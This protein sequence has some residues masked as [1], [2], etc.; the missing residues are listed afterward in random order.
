MCGMKNFLYWLQE[1]RMTVIPVILVIVISIFNIKLLAY[2]ER[3]WGVFSANDFAFAE[4]PYE[5]KE[6]F[7]ELDSATNSLASTYSID[8]FNTEEQINFI[9]IDSGYLL[10]KNNPL[11]DILPSRDGL[12]IYKVQKGDNLAKIA[13]NFGISLNTIL[14]A[15][16]DLNSNLLKIGQEV[17]I[18][19]VSGVLH[20]ILLGDTIES[21]SEKYSVSVNK[22]V[23]YNIGLSPSKLESRQTIIV[24]YAKP[25]QSSSMAQKLP[26][27][28]GYFAIPTTGWNWGILHNYNAVDIANACGTSV[29][30]S[31]EGLVI[32]ELPSGWNGGFGR[33]ILIEHPNNTKTRYAHMQKNTVSVGDY[34]LQGDLVGYIGNTGLTHGP[35]GC[36]LHF[37]IIGAKNPFA[38]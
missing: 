5:N 24:P 14:W 32:E 21:I 31:A 34:V 10:N 3:P 27:Y 33:Y 23:A 2:L 20:N 18:L 12:L 8:Y 22:I 11:S 4:S 35:T 36:H 37:E 19:P 28:P 13:T 16:R 30:A 1:H 38:K 9:V 26:N 6:S 15:N 17:V 7:N 25:L 29:Y